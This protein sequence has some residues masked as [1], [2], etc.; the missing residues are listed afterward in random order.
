[1][2]IFL[3]FAFLFCI[4]SVLGWVLELFYRNIRF[5]TPNK[6]GWINP[7]F[8]TGPYLPIY[9]CG[10]C[11]LYLIASS[12][13]FCFFENPIVNRCVIF[14]LIAVCMTIIEYIAGIIL[15]KFYNIRLWDYSNEFG[16]I[17]GIICPKYSLM[18]T[19][20]GAVY[21]FVVH[22]YILEALDWLSHNL[23]FSF[24]I[25]VFFGIFIIDIINSMQLVEKV[26]RFANENHIIIKY[27]SIKETIKGYYKENKKRYNFFRPFRTDKP[28]NEHLLDMQKNFERLSK[29]R[30][31]H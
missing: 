16:N 24:V 9:G 31:K 2:S 30:N 25:G 15:L 26:K 21:Y 3:I 5:K 7:G 20:L 14:L 27:D 28:L 18:W 22:S 11:V 4:G 13:V 8:C 6:S 19:V 23:A 1:M 10:L 29:K 12:E 17:G